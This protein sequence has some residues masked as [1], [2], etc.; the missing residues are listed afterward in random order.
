MEWAISNLVYNQSTMEKG[1]RD[2]SKTRSDNGTEH[3][4]KRPRVNNVFKDKSNINQVHNKGSQ[5]RFYNTKPSPV[6][7]SQQ[8]TD[9]KQCV[10]DMKPSMDILREIL[11]RLSKIEER[12]SEAEASDRS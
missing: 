11:E 10:T 4:L 9:I 12:Y 8:E 7:V 6:I 2:R 1:K 5:T 3:I